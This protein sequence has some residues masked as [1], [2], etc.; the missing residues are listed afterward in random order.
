VS[1]HL[2][3][4]PPRDDPDSGL[5][6]RATLR[7]MHLPGVI[8]GVSAN[9]KPDGD[10]EAQAI[11]YG[12][13]LRWARNEK[14]VVSLA[15][16]GGLPGFGSYYVFYPEFGFGVVSFA[17]VTYAGASGATLKAAARLI[18]TAKIA[19]RE[20]PVSS[21][22]QA[23]K[24]QVAELIQAWDLKLANSIVA[25]NFLPDRSRDDRMAESRELL[26]KLGAIR[27]IGE[28]APE[29]QLRGTFAISGEHGHINVYFTLTPEKSAKL[30]QLR[31]TF[32][33]NT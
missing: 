26:G 31:M 28:M 24:Q 12:F 4:Y 29:N 23:R 18:E 3:A 8:S 32:V 13:G 17:N 20:L 30:Q 15:H 9:R 2:S 10:G 7:E 21:T 5:V 1:F 33:A 25:E 22:L 14:D 11:G 27:F 19:G 16:G 6:R